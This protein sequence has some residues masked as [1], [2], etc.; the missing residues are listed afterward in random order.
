MMLTKKKYSAKQ[1]KKKTT[2][3]L[4]NENKTNPK[5]SS[6]LAQDFLYSVL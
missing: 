6:S 4:T 1:Q 5:H 2:Q 3:K